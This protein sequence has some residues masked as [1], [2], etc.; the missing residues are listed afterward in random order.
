[1]SSF[2]GV[3]PRTLQKYDEIGKKEF[4]E[5]I[6]EWSPKTKDGS[7]YVHFHRMII[8]AQDRAYRDAVTAFLKGAINEPKTAQKYLAIVDPDNWAEHQKVD[9]GGSLG[10]TMKEI[11]EIADEY[12]KKNGK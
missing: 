8:G 6:K 11:H 12:E 5:G 9:L 2:A 4:V 3:H 7:Y 1:M 10:V